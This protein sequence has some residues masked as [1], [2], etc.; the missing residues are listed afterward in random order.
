MSEAD[1]P[2]DGLWKLDSEDPCCAKPTVVASFLTESLELDRSKFVGSTL[3]LTVERFDGDRL[4]DLRTSFTKPRH[5]LAQH[6]VCEGTLAF[7]AEK[8]G[9]IPFATI[10][11]RVPGGEK[12]CGGDPDA[13]RTEEAGG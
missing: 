9:L 11:L 13:R 12:R 1:R 7:R 5:L 6:K 8:R 4:W 10:G 2:A 3:V